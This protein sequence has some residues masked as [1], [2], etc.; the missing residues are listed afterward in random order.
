MRPLSLRPGS[1]S[2]EFSLSILT[3]CTPVPNA[4]LL[5]P[6]TDM[7]ASGAR[8]LTTSFKFFPCSLPSPLQS[9][10]PVFDDPNSVSPTSPKEPRIAFSISP[11]SDS[12]AV[13]LCRFDP[14]DP[15]EL[16]TS[17]SWKFSGHRT[18]KAGPPWFDAYFPLSEDSLAYDC[19]G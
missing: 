8:W 14:S 7:A 5:A 1:G 17:G 16:R 19:C 3:M 6:E 12:F 18:R 15:A 2:P 11:F 4:T 10:P 9:I 13:L